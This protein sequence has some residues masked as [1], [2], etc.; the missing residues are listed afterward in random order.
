[1]VLIHPKINLP[2]GVGRLFPIIKANKDGKTIPSLSNVLMRFVRKVTS[3]KNT[4]VHS[5][6]STFKDMLRDAAVS[7]EIKDFITG[8]SSSDEA[9]KYG[10]GSSLK[11]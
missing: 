1:M 5:L 9:S 4:V 11:F 2:D 10:S 3:D 7:K 8:H 6:R